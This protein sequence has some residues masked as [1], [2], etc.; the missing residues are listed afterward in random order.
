MK[1]DAI[2]ELA[3]HKRASFMALAKEHKELITR[4]IGI[5]DCLHVTHKLLY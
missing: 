5:Q 4:I 2:F 1:R 3:L